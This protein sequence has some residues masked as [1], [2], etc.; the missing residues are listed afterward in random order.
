MAIDIS[1]TFDNK[2]VRDFL[3]S[4]ARNYKA[5][6]EKKSKFTALLSVI[7]FQD[8]MDHFKSEQGPRGAWVEW[9]RIY[10]AH[11]EREGRSGNKKLQ[12]SG[13]MRN[14]FTPQKVRTS[15]QGIL[16]FNNAVTRGGFPYA[17]A[18]EEGEGR[19]PARPFMWLSESAINKISEQALQFLVEEG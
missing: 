17:R 18:H 7:V 6:S 8:I 4:V 5:I 3:T 19:I 16:W 2:E 15:S 13:R 10:I 14:T 9:S 12:Y 11:L 1:A